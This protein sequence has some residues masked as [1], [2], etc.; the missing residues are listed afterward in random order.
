[1]WYIAIISGITIFLKFIYLSKFLPGENPE[2]ING[3]NK[4][5]MLS[6]DKMKALDRSSVI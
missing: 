3:S 4:S 2:Q 6:D 5:Q 1:M